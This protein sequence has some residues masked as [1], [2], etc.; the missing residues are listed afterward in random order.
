MERL[1]VNRKR[2]KVEAISILYVVL[3]GL[4]VGT[5]LGILMS[6]DTESLLLGRIIGAAVIGVFIGLSIGVIISFQ[7]FSVPFQKE[8]KTTSILHFRIIPKGQKPT[9]VPRPPLV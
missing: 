4:I 9:V 2:V 6:P 8:E 3:S 5:A 7:L 1:V